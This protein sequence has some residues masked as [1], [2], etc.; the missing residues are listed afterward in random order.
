M[1]FC[2]ATL[3]GYVLLDWAKVVPERH[4]QWLPWLPLV[5]LVPAA[6][7]LREKTH[8]VERLVAFLPI[9]AATAFL[10]VPG[11]ERLDDVR[12]TYLFAVGGCAFVQCAAWDWLAARTKPLMFSVLACLA[13]GGTAGLLIPFFVLKYGEMLLCATGATIGVGLLSVRSDNSERARA[14]APLIAVVLTAGTFIGFV[15]PD[16]AES[17]V[18]MPLL[19]P[20]IALPLSIA[21]GE[22]YGRVFAV[23]QIC[24][25]L[26]LLGGTGWWLQSQQEEQSD[27]YGEYY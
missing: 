27:E 24:L 18:L 4:Y 12:W 3:T 13:L 6:L 15:E 5:A 22:R 9:A 1:A 25:I 23:V 20:V 14:I 26:A 19:V 10:I 11:W 17:A 8:I 16:P 7:S 2:A 21:G